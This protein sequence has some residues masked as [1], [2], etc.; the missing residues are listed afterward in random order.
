MNKAQLAGVIDV[1][2]LHTDSTLE[3][4]LKMAELAKA[5]HLHG[6]DGVAVFYPMLLEA[7]QGSGVVMGSACGFIMITSQLKAVFARRNI[8]M[9]C[10]EC[11]M[12]INMPALKSGLYEDVVK[13]IR[14]IKDAVGDH[15]LKCI[16]ETPLLSDEEICKACE[17][18]VE[19][20]ADFVKTAGGHEGETTLHHV[21][22]AAKALDGRAGLIAAGGIKD[23]NTALS[24]LEAGAVRLGIEYDAVLDLLNEV[25]K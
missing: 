6:V 10:D 16:I 7:L 23:L 19:G 22:V 2:L 14:M 21:Q 11:E 20:G 1:S 13:E 12:T 15:L 8:E 24:M 9:G 4:T 3:K 17:L 18:A 5:H 25:E